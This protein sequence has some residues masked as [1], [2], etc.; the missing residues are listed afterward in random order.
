MALALVG[1]MACS[2][3]NSGFRSPN[4]YTQEDSNPVRG[5]SYILSPV[6]TMLEYGLARPLHYLATQTFLQ[7]V[8]DP[9]R[10]ADSWEEYY[11][12]ATDKV[13]LPPIPSEEQA[14]RLDEQPLS[15]LS[16]KDLGNTKPTNPSATPDALTPAP[17]DAGQ[18]DTSH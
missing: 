9:S 8:L 4:E 6:G 1:G 18:K 10:D 11:G 3:Q 16:E 13:P 5:I 7:P 14:D 17:P 12:S 2:Q 15:R